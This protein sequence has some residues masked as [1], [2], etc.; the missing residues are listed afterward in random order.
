[1]TVVQHWFILLHVYKKYAKRHNR[2]NRY[3]L[4][5][6]LSSNQYEIYINL[7]IYETLLY[8]YEYKKQS[9]SKSRL[10][11]NRWCAIFWQK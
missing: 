2:T 4:F 9:L 1:M 11:D 3:M 8:E 6:H 5:E 7:H 10:F